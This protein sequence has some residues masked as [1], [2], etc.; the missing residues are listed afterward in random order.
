MEAVEGTL[1]FDY[2][3][4]NDSLNWYNYTIYLPCEFY[5][6]ETD[7]MFSITNNDTL[8]NYTITVN[9]EDIW[10][11]AETATTQTHSA[12]DL[13]GF[14][15]DNTTA[16]L[17]IS[18]WCNHTDNEI[19]IHVDGD[20]V[21][22][23]QVWLNSGVWAQTDVNTPNVGGHWSV[24]DTITIAVNQYDVTDV[25]M[26][27]SYPKEKV[28]LPKTLWVNDTDI[29]VGIP[30]EGYWV[31]QK[32]GPA[33]DLDEDDIEEEITGST[34]TVTVEF[35]SDDELKDADWNINTES[36]VWG[37]KFA[38]LDESTLVIKINDDELDE[39][40]WKIGSIEMEN[41]DIDD[42]DNVVTFTW[43]VPSGGGGVTPSEAQPFDWESEPI[44][45]VPLPAWA[46]GAV[47][48]VIIVAA[49][50]IWKQEK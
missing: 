28:G 50:L 33:N 25:D 21:P 11:H 35:D 18:I 49:V 42:D 36:T 17:E 29:D 44:A 43:T 12:Q 2:T 10:W 1:D 37:G 24:N 47:A 48:L 5:Y 39:D 45:G 16:V 41:V 13:A 46:I 9:N 20:D 32:N 19:E 34:H 3:L 8:L 4:T 7:P 40:D 6:I 23:A 27:L 31:Y 14:M 30:F 26:L 38:S 15:T 22:I